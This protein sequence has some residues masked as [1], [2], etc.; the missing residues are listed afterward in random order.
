MVY[1]PAI[2]QKQKVVTPGGLQAEINRVMKATS[3]DGASN[4]NY[5]QR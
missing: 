1:G 4:F 2:D 3:L 5:F